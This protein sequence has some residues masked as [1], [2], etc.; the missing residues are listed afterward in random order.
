MPR[1][2]IKRIYEPAT[3]A[4]GY[5]VLVDG[6][7][8]RGVSKDDAAIDH[9]ARDLAPSAGLRKWFRHDP[10]KWDEFQRRYREELADRQASLDALA[11]KA[12]EGPVTLLFSAKDTDHNQAVV[13]RDVLNDR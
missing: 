8:P 5:R 7:W 9:W 1:V 2:A 10:G 11:R 3:S 12:E 13:L 4:D 6:V